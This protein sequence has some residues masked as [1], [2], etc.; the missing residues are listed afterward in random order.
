MSVGKTHVSNVIRR[1]E[2]DIRI[3]RREVRNRKLKAGIPNRVWGVDLTGKTDDN[4][5]LHPV[6]G[7]IDHGTHANLALT[8]LQNKTTITLLRALLDVIE[9]AGKPQALR[10]DNEGI[11][12][13]R[14][15]RFGLWMLGITHQ[16]TDP[17]CPWQNGRIE[18]FFGTLKQKLDQWTVANRDQL[19]A[20]L[21]VFRLWY[22]HIRP[23]Q[24]LQGHTPAEIWNDVDISR[25]PP[26]K[27]IWFDAWDG[28]LT[29]YYLRR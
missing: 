8:A 28:L 11:F 13:S 6:L 9:Q 5:R 7:V 21:H 14:L 15:F 27:A 10:T 23:H 25:Q 18:R 19:N 29:G 1:H 16:R 22:N 3:A 26:R 17:H 20:S 2:Y 24:H 12:T 4:G